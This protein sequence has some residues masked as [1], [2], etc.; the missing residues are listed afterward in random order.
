[1]RV[2]YAK[3][4]LRYVMAMLVVSV[5]LYLL[6]L[7]FWPMSL[8]VLLAGLWFVNNFKD[9][10]AERRYDAHFARP[11]E[12]VTLTD[13]PL[14]GDGVLIGYAYQDILAVRPGTAGKKELGHF[15]WFG[16]NR[17]GKGLSITS[18]LLQWQGSAI[19]VDIK[20]EISEAT[21]GYRKEVLGQEV[22]ILNPSSFESSHQF[23][24]FAELETDEQIFS[25]ATG[26]MS[27]DED[28]ENAVFAQ[29]ASAALAAIIKA[30]KVNG[31][32]VIPT[33]DGLLY[34]PEGMKGATTK[35]YKLGDQMVNKWLTAFLSKAPDKMDWEAAESDRFLKNSWQRLVTQAQY[36]TT[37]GVI[38][39][40]GGSDFKAQ[41][42]IDKKV[43]VYLVF[44]ESELELTLPLFNLVVD[45]IIRSI[46]RKYDMNKEHYAQHGTKVLGVFDEAYRATPFH[47]PD[48]SSTVSGRGIYMCM[49]VQSLAQLSERWG[50]GGK[51]T[52]LDN[53]HTKIFLPSVDRNES[54]KESTSAFVSSSVGK[55]MVEDRSLNKQ[56]HAHELSSGIRLTERELITAS[57]FGQL[58]PTQS[59]II[60][61]ELP[62]IFAHRLEP[63]RFKAFETATKLPLPKLPAKAAPAPKLKAK[64]KAIP[65]A[66]Q[67]KESDV[68]VMDRSLLMQEEE[69]EKGAESGSES[70]SAPPT[71]ARSSVAPQH[72]LPAD[73]DSVKGH[74][75]DHIIGF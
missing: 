63:W 5:S 71:P 40:T 38:H 64:S 37:D 12:L 53:V 15:M 54:D 57:E 11:Q 22:Y 25:A 55:Y 39:M 49:Y 2:N 23:D 7:H 42:L 62:P 61:N 58:K 28:G 56:E 41:D 48:Y 26:F 30:A 20:G 3:F 73:A 33:L 43:T 60:S 19:V 70:Q 72:L 34:D 29:R 27:P 4:V 21:A 13:D 14:A 65:A 50:K 45:A 75:D 16:P 1:M 35:L 68:V 17:S 44:R 67:A 24:P 6:M 10:V 9:T 18:N 46:L 32:P 59:I 52:L 8:A 51:T 47:M 74:E 69:A 66:A 36:L 31:W